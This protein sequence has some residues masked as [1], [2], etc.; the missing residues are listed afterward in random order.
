[1]KIKAA[2]AV[3]MALACFAAPGR[4]T[5]ALPQP[6]ATRAPLAPW[7]Q[8]DRP[9]TKADLEAWLDGYLPFALERGD[10][11]GAVVVVVK[12]GQVLLQKGYGY[13]DVAAK[14]PIDPEITMFRPGSVSKLFTWTALMQ[15]VEAGKV[16]LDADVNT[17][18]DFK[19]PPYQGKP[20]TVRNLMT[21]TTGFEEVI[22]NLMIT[23]PKAV[24]P[25]GPTLK[26]HLP[27]RIFPP[28]EVPAYSNYGAALAGRIIERVSGQAFDDYID[29]HIFTPLDMTHSSFRQPLPDRLK[30]FVAQGY[31]LASGPPQPYELISAGPAGSSAVSG[32][33]MARFMIAQ[34]QDGAYQGRRILEPATA[35]SMHSTPLTIISP[36]LHRMLLG[37]Y[38]TDRNGRRIIAHGGDLR[39]FHSDLDL[40]PDDGV[41][42]FVSFNSLGRDGAVYPVREA[43]VDAFIDR[44]FPGAPPAGHVDPATA[45]ADAQRLA[46]DYDGSRRPQDS[47]M[48]LLNLLSQAKVTADKNGYVSASPLTGLNGQPKRFEEIAPLVWREVGGKD[49]LAAKAAGGHV[50][51]WSE[52]GESP[53]LVYQP[54]PGY[55]N[56]AWL[57]PALFASL[58]ALWMTALSWPLVALVRWRYGARF[59][60]K[61]MSA[62][63]YRGVRI[64]ALT[65]SLV[66]TAWLITILTMLQNYAFGANLDPWIMTLHLLS[67]VIFPLAA[68]SAVFDAFIAFTQRKGWRSVFAWTWS[69][70]VA[71]STLILLWTG[72]VFHLIGVG[73]RY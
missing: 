34:L 23:D 11:A 70:V 12:D 36:S 5:Q 25:L 68:L 3:L 66:M 67:I 62:L 39:W 51:M 64:A 26:S 30:P 71:L 16:S 28:G 42:L 52:D 72:I 31:A 61:G 18:L 19:I 50:V 17:Y 1:M 57:K 47:F 48:S 45:K 7:A 58:A 33:D 13:A 65:S 38:E 41:G 20:I 10:V 60:L 29:Q 21:H 14:K 54:T 9:L 43:L 63:S 32:G 56:G 69:L 4:A 15:L 35:Q 27:D 73:L 59:A 46:G 49:R 40:F 53:F 37:F 22:K 2:V 6:S 8:A 44:Y 55:R 24:P